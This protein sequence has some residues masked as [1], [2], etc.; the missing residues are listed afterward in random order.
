MLFIVVPFFSFYVY[1][2]DT[3]QGIAKSILRGKGDRKQASKEAAQGMLGS[4]PSH[5]YQRQNILACDSSKDGGIVLWSM[6]V[7]K[8]QTKSRQGTMKAGAKG[9]MTV[10]MR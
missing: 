10:L 6:C 5:L 4:I 9:R 3:F 2:F 7:S 8:E 1:Q